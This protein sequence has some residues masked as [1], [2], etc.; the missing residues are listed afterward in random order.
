MPRVINPRHERF[1][2]EYIKCGVAARAYLAAGYK[3]TTRHSLDTSA[4]DLLRHP[5][6]KRLLTL[7]RVRAMKRTDITVD[8]LLSDLEADRALAHGE[9]QGSAAVQATMAKAR[10][11]GLI[12]DRKETGKPGEFEG[13]QTA[14]DVI[15][16]VRTEFGDT[17]ADAL[18]HELAAQEQ[19]REEERRAR[20]RGAAKPP[21][22]SGTDSLN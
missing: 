14:A 21:T 5:E 17:V 1:A 15:Q 3:P 16:A 4:S 2:R 18:A 7:H 8:T 10:L 20:T 19:P 6:V 22:N 11:L 13:L 9:G 12:V